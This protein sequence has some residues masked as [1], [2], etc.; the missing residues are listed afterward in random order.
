MSLF[1][2]ACRGEISL[3]FLFDKKSYIIISL[4]YNPHH[5]PVLQDRA[6]LTMKVA[7]QVQIADVILSKHHFIYAV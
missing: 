6:L 3:E 5:R 7:Q 1:Y 4:G 2:E